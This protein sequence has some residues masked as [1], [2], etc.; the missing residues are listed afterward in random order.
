MRILI[1]AGLLLLR[2]LMSSGLGATMDPDVCGIDFSEEVRDVLRRR[3]SWEI[4]MK[5][6][7]NRQDILQQRKEAWSQYSKTLQNYSSSLTKDLRS[8]AETMSSFYNEQISRLEESRQ[9]KEETRIEKATLEEKRERLRKWQEY[10]ESLSKYSESST[11]EICK[12][13]EKIV[14]K[15]VTEINTLERIEEMKTETTTK[16]EESVQEVKETKVEETKVEEKKEENK[17]EE[18]KEETKAEERKEET[19][20]EEKREEKKVE[21][22]KEEKIDEKSVK[23]ERSTY[24]FM[25]KLLDL[26]DYNF[27]RFTRDSKQVDWSTESKTTQ[28]HYE[29]YTELR[30]ELT[31][32]EITRLDSVKQLSDKV[33]TCARL[34]RTD[35]E[36]LATINEELARIKNA[37]KFS[38]KN[39]VSSQWASD[40]LMRLDLT[41]KKSMTSRSTV[42]SHSK[43]VQKSFTD[44]KKQS[45]EHKS[46][47]SWSQMRSEELLSQAESTGRVDMESVKTIVKSSMKIT[48][49]RSEETS[50]WLSKVEE[51]T[52]SSSM[53]TSQSKEFW[54]E[55][56]FEQVESKKSSLSTSESFSS[57]STI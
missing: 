5:S 3:E 48:D 37:H 39:Q 17:V 9:V 7:A 18:R 45:S 44:L 11:R 54:S 13:V 10:R 30:T 1:Y 16:K 50:T 55:A 26:V 56:S 4:F 25:S 31:N 14:E 8:M 6:I 57:I 43:S 21:E 15:L 51:S 42:S 29:S 38:Q 32:E 36:G 35:F 28:E 46:V 27:R 19:K 2:P 52:T 33:V 53:W 41:L 47:A 24:R 49:E 34:G 40:W 22:K 20:V 23:I 12:V